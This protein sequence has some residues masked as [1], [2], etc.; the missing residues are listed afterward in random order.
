MSHI[1]ECYPMTHTG[2]LLTQDDLAKHDV[3]NG[4]AT[5]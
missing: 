4:D 3:K 2:H 1:Q 5:C